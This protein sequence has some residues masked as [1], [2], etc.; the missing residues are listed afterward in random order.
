MGT[1]GRVRSAFPADHS[2]RLIETATPEE[3]DGEP[4]TQG[5]QRRRCEILDR[6]MP[7]GREPLEVLQDSGV[8]PKAA[9]DPHI[10][11]ARTIP[12][13]ADRR[14]PGVGY[15]VFK[16]AGEPDSHSVQ[17]RQY[18]KETEPFPRPQ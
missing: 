5:S 12:R 17:L 15:E 1:A 9:N 8:H 14:G 18:V 3:G 16:L 2:T 13:N 7:T 10:A 6:R 11:A 4:T